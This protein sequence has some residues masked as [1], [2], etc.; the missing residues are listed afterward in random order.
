M[1]PLL[2]DVPHACETVKVFVYNEYISAL[3]VYADLS[4]LSKREKENDNEKI[5]KWIDSELTDKLTSEIVRKSSTIGLN[6]IPLV[7]FNVMRKIFA[8]KNRIPETTST[9][10]TFQMNEIVDR[11]KT[12]RPGTLPTILHSPSLRTNAPKIAQSLPNSHA[13]KI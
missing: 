2:K 8:L 5:V 6:Y 7:Q 4:F 1:L 11:L 3:E 12:K 13:Q 10:A 9:D